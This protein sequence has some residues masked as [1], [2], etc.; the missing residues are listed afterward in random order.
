MLCMFCVCKALH[1]YMIDA[2]FN[3]HVNIVDRCLDLSAK[4]MP[5]PLGNNPSAPRQGSLRGFRVSSWNSM[6]LGRK[7]SKGKEALYLRFALPTAFVTTKSNNAHVTCIS[8]GTLCAFSFTQRKPTG[9]GLAMPGHDIGAKDPT[10]PQDIT[11]VRLP[12]VVG[13]LKARSFPAICLNICLV[14]PGFNG[15]LSVPDMFLILF[16]GLQRANGT[17]DVFFPAVGVKGNLSLFDILSPFFAR[18]KSNWRGFLRSLRLSLSPSG[19]HGLLASRGFARAQAPPTR[20]GGAAL[21]RTTRFALPHPRQPAVDHHPLGLATR[22]KR[23]TKSHAHGKSNMTHLE[24][25][26]S[27]APKHVRQDLHFHFEIW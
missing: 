8:S 25:G 20:R 5:L 14:F 21:Q 18:R 27:M 4:S 24:Y 3:G 9:A 16:Q 1:A 17:S 10:Q 7:E 11:L 13:H 26:Y 19:E 23:K 22:A 2:F 12:L 15:N 6:M